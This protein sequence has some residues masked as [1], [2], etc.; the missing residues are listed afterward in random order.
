MA[1]EIL[2]LDENGSRVAGAVTDDSNKYITNLRVDPT[3]LRLKVDA[4]ITSGLSAQTG[5]ID[6]EA[7]DAAD[8]GVLMLGTD[9]TNY[10][11]MKV[12]S[13]G[14]LQV[15]L[16]SGAEFAEDAAHSSGATGNYIL[17]VRQD[18]DTSPVSTD[19]DYHGLI[20]DNAGNLKVNVKISALPSG[21]ATSAKQDLLLAEL[22]LKAD[23]TETQPV[24]LATVPSHA[25]TNAGVFATQIDGAA[26]TALQLIDNLVL[27]E[28]A[29]HQTGDP[30]VQL[31]AVR[32]DTLDIR[33]GAENDYEPLHTNANGA[34]WVID[35]NSAA[36]ATSLGVLDNAISGSEMQ[37]DVVAALPTGTNAL[38]RV[39]HDHTGIAHGVTTVT[40]AGT[41]V[42]L[43]G[44]TACKRALIQSQT[45]N[46]G[47]IAVGATGVDATEATGTG[48]ILYPGDSVTI[49][50]DN[51]ADV[52]IDSTVSGEGVR[53]TY[54]T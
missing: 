8:F 33:S 11:V 30:G 21:A 34:L 48:I 22:Q 23:L 20:F 43:A 1:S 42:V 37:V 6:G 45:D 3:T 46:T 29:A 10:Q 13:N 17:G 31:L 47:L 44:S 38:G 40:T 7:V 25:V 19:G 18:A 24:S 54:F 41:D 2:K 4:V 50:I 52:F 15:D 26:L 9:G 35:V 36:M 28:D 12:D 16:V 32:D 53:Y 49:D 27:L 51:L 5:V 39:G 14:Q